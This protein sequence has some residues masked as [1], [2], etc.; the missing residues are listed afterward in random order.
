MVRTELVYRSRRVPV[1]DYP[2]FR[3]FCLAV[4]RAQGLSVVLAP[5]DTP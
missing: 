1:A 3:E 4:D 5:E 2:A